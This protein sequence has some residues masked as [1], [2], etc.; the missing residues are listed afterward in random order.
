MLLTIPH[1]HTYEAVEIKCVVAAKMI[2]CRIAYVT[3]SHDFLRAVPAFFYVCNACAVVLCVLS[4]QTKKGLYNCYFI[5][6]IYLSGYCA[7][8]TL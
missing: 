7:E 6:S 2:P 8:L 3:L 4:L 5:L 1:G